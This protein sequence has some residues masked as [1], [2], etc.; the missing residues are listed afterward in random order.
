MGGLCFVSQ[1]DNKGFTYILESNSGRGYFELLKWNSHC[2]A[3]RVSLLSYL[4]GDLTNDAKGRD[5]KGGLCVCA[6]LSI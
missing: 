3:Y 4:G 5:E 6:E 2:M 1:D